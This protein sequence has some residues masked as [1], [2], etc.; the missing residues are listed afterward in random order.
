MNLLIFIIKAKKYIFLPSLNH[1]NTKHR[2]Y[3]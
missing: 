3:F 1:K 2:G